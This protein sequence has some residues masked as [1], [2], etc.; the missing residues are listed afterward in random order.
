MLPVEKREAKNTTDIL[1]VK[2]SEKWDRQSSK[3]TVIDPGN[4]WTVSNI[5]S[6]EE[7]QDLIFHSQMMGYTE[8]PLTMGANNFIMMKDVR[9]NT[10]VIWDDHSFAEQLWQRLKYFVPVHAKYLNNRQVPYGNNFKVLGCNERFRFYKYQPMER[11]APHYDG[12]F[13]KNVGLQIEKSF[14]TCIIY[15]NTVQEGG[16]TN[17]LDPRNQSIKCSVK[18]QTGNCLL[19]V[20]ENYHEGALIPKD[21]KEVKYVIRTDIMYKN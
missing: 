1:N 3:I 8:A 7:C 9:N 4:I 17:F 21:S 14:L 11:F 18:P 5:L 6:A 2:L 10:R 13:S 20:H 12:C 15:L 19:F 16:C